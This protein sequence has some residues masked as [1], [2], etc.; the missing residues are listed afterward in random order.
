MGTTRT[1]TSERREQ[2]YEDKS[3]D[4][5]KGNRTRKGRPDY[6]RKAY[7]S[8]KS[9]ALR[10]VRGRPIVIKSHTLCNETTDMSHLNI[11]SMCNIIVNYNKGEF[12]WCGM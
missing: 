10:Q 12:T 11:S 9:K 8:R 3:K 1:Q 2:E 7:N 6:N 5:G 4:K